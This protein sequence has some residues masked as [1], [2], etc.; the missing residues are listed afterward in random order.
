MKNTVKLILLF[1]SLSILSGSDYVG[2]G[3]FVSNSSSARTIALSYAN[4]A[5]ASGLESVYSN[6]A[7]LVSM[8]ELRFNAGWSLNTSSFMKDLKYQ[9]LSIGYGRKIYKIPEIYMAIGFGYQGFKVDDIDE[10][11]KFENYQSTFNFSEAA[12]NFLTAF[13]IYTLSMGL[14]WTYYSQNFGSYGYSHSNKEDLKSKFF[15]PTEL[16]MQ[17]RIT[18]KLM[19]GVIYNK[20]TRIGLYDIT[21]ARLKFGIARKDK[22]LNYGLDYER[23][24]TDKGRIMTGVEYTKDIYNIPISFRFGGRGNINDDPNG[25][26]IKDS[27]YLTTGIG[28]RFNEKNF[29]KKSFIFNF[30]LNQSTYP[31]IVTPIVRMVYISVDFY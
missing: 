6:S 24:S 11:D 23:L 4:T 14:K 15:R 8:T 17:Y 27:I 30:A 26:K 18:K 5:W 1:I 25:W 16:G 19:I 9:S 10:Y 31:N 12:Y 13:R 7:G 22:S 21:P 3:S 28:I 2:Y 29:L 20:S